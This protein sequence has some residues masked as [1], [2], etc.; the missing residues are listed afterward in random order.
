MERLSSGAQ[1]PPH[2]C[3]GPKPWPPA[4]THWEQKLEYEELICIVEMSSMQNH[5]LY[6]PHMILYDT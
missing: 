2:L 4:E 1:C 3:R 6:F 5:I